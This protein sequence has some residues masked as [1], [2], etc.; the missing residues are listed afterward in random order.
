MNDLI[1]Q[2][3]VAIPAT[4]FRVVEGAAAFAALPEA[5]PRAFPAAYVVPLDEV[6]DG[7]PRELGRMTQRVTAS[8][9]IILFA[10]NLAG[11][12]GGAAVADLAALRLAVR[13]QLLG[14]APADAGAMQFA[15]G[16]LLGAAAGRLTWQDSY[17]T[18]FDITGELAGNIF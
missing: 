17:S 9:G 10:Q 8:F 7:R 16:S 6:P 15:G 12:A 11:A 18:D 4:P 1:V 2:R 14:W 3:L 13:R 5:G